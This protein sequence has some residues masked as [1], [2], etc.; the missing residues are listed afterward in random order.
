MIQGTTPT[1]TIHL[2]QGAPDM[3]G[4]KRVSLTLVQGE[5]TLCVKSPSPRMWLSKNHVRVRLT[6]EETLRFA[7]GPVELQLRW[8]DAEGQAG[9]SVP[10]TLMN[11]GLLRG[12]VLR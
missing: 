9:A 5:R 4:Q 8:L 7:P 10:A 1:L 3:T 6:Q 12:E 11:Y 2:S